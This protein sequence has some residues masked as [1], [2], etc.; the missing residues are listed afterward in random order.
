MR[1]AAALFAS[2]IAI[3]LPACSGGGE[4]AQFQRELR[5]AEKQAR[6]TLGV[7]WERF[8]APTETEYDFLVRAEIAQ[9][10]DDARREEVWIEV[11]SRTPATG[12]I[13]GMLA[14][15]PEV[16]TGLARGDRVSLDEKDVIDWAYF[17]GMQLLGHY[18]TRVR[19]PTM[20]PDQAEAL[21]SL[22]GENPQ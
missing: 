7:F 2:L 12:A 10:D 16:L 11:L 15:E 4:E 9:P 17:S 21:R 18:T 20:P 14:S 1:F 3:S 22:L 5:A 13:E 6:S 8:S 19:L